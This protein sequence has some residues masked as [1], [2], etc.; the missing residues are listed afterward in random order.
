MS[1]YFSMRSEKTSINSLRGAI[2]IHTVPRIRQE[3]SV[4]YSLV[5]RRMWP[6]FE[7]LVAGFRRA[8]GLLLY[9]PPLFPE[10]SR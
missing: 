3:A 7:G 5:C 6:V 9:R 1:G 10:Y 4:P 2:A 8:K